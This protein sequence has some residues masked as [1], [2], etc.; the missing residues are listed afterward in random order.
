MRR[1]AVQGLPQLR[2][3]RVRLGP[4]PGLGATPVVG[5]GQGK[6][7]AAVLCIHSVQLASVA[8]VVAGVLAGGISLWTTV[9]TTGPRQVAATTS[10]FIKRLLKVNVCKVGHP[11]RC[12]SHP[13]QGM[14]ALG[15]CVLIFGA[16][17]A[18]HHAAQCMAQL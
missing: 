6:K 14:R 5:T 12:E 11:V 3:V 17:A 2:L 16:A 15:L 8:S 10:S 18:R 1:T 7:T 13:V 9:W 4:G